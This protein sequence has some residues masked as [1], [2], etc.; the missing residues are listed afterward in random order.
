MN[1]VYI[2]SVWNDFNKARPVAV[3]FTFT[4]YTDRPPIAWGSL[5]LLNFGVCSFARCHHRPVLC[6]GSSQWHPMSIRLPGLEF[7]TRPGLDISDDNRPTPGPKTPRRL[8]GAISRRQGYNLYYLWGPRV[9]NIWFVCAG[10]CNHPHAWAR[11]CLHMAFVQ[12]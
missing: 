6:R 8:G 5:F 1:Y 10:N 12:P 9:G 7:V 11:H 2:D 4:Q 3:V